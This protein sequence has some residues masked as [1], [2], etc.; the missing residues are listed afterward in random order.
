MSRENLELILRRRADGYKFRSVH[1]AGDPDDFDFLNEQLTHIARDLDGRRGSGWQDK[2]ELIVRWRY[3]H[4]LI[5]GG[6]EP[7]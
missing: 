5:V 6:Q 2:Y 3:G 1:V 7:R 4:E